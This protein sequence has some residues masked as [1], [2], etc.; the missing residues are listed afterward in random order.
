MRE[1]LGAWRGKKAASRQTKRD[2]QREREQMRMR[3]E[4]MV[5]LGCWTQTRL[6]GMVGV[7]SCV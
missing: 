2:G 1:W 3:A 7:L 6:K 4:M 5:Q